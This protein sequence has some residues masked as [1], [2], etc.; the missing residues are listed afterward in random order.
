MCEKKIVFKQNPKIRRYSL[1][2]PAVQAQ[3]RIAIAKRNC[4]PSPSLIEILPPAPRFSWFTMRAAPVSGVTVAIV[5]CLMLM[6]GLQIGLHVKVHHNEIAEIAA[7]SST[8]MKKGGIGHAYMD[9]VRGGGKADGIQKAFNDGDTTIKTGGSGTT[10]KNDNDKP[11]PIPTPKPKPPPKPTIKPILNSPPEPPT[12]QQQQQQLQQQ[13]QQQQQQEQQEQEQ[14]QQQQQQEQQ[15]QQQHP[16]GPI[17]KYLEYNHLP[18]LLVTKDRLDYLENTLNSLLQTVRPTASQSL[19]SNEGNN[20]VDGKPPLWDNIIVA[21]DGVDDGV[22]DRLTKVKNDNG[23]PS[24]AFKLAKNTR[25]GQN[26]RGRPDGAMMIATHYNFAIQSGLD[27]FPDSPGIIIAEDDFLFSPDFLEFFES[28]AIAMDHDDTIFVISA[29]ND[30]GQNHQV[31]DKSQLYRTNYFPGLGWFLSRKLWENELMSKWPRTHWDHWMRDEKQYA[32]RDCVY[33]EVTR[34]FHAGIKGTFM[35][36]NT[37]EKY[38]KDVGYQTDNSFRWT[39][40]EWQTITPRTGYDANLR[41]LVEGGEVVDN[42]ETLSS[43]APEGSA[44][45]GKHKIVWIHVP[46]YKNPRQPF[47]PIG[48]YFHIWHEIERANYNGVHRFWFNNHPVILINIAESATLKEMKGQNDRV[49]KPND[50]P[51]FS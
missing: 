40:L 5:A 37:H 9:L 46:D 1:G 6:V 49:F 32:S 22:L 38:F 45:A 7:S 51:P 13:Q 25:K 30:N 15:Q 27:E 41:S 44:Q 12:A 42:I 28:N 20:L 17:Q 26:L 8:I 23:L 11:P 33:P 39:G 21:Q 16:V 18:I 19:D 36:L 10:S 14:Q 31:K 2:L 3:A 29:W 4:R 34:T 48:N 35:D 50:F 47:K 24:S 43:P